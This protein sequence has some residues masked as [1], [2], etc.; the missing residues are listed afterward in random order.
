[1]LQIKSEDSPGPDRAALAR[2]WIE[3]NGRGGYASSTVLN[4]HTRKYHGLLVANLDS[5]PGRHVLFSQFEDSLL[6]PDREYFLSCHQYPG[7]FFPGNDWILKEYRIDPFPSFL[8]RTEGLCL[9]KTILLLPA[10]DCLLV[11]YDIEDCPAK[12]TLRLKPFIAFRGYHD[13]SRRNPWLNDRITSVN[14]GFFLEPYA[15]MPSLFIQTNVKSKFLAAPLW[16]DAFEYSLEGERGYDRHEDL[17]LPGTIEVPVRKGA[18]VVVTAATKPQGKQPKRLWTEEV[19]RRDLQAEERN[20]FASKFDAQDR[21]YIK[22]LIRAGRQFLIRTPAG[23]PAVIAGYHWFG[24]WG[25]DTLISLPGLTFC[26]NRLQEGI[27]ILLEISEHEWEGLLPNCFFAEGKEPSYNS[28]DASLW[29]FWTVQQMLR[30]NGAIA[31][32]KDRFWP[33]MK[34]ILRKFMDGTVHDIRVG[35]NGLLHAG[36]TGSNLTW[37]DASVD[38]TPV[39]PRWGC[40]VE[41]NALWYNAVCFADKLSRDFG[42]EEFSFTGLIPMIRHSF[43]KTFWSERDGHL[44]DVFCNGL[45]D[46][47]IRPNQIFAISLPYPEAE[48][49]MTPEQQASVVQVVQEHLLTPCGLRTLSP[50]H[51]DYQGRYGGNTASRDRAYHQGTVWPWLLGH[52]GEAY[53]GV[54]QE[55]AAAKAFLLRHLRS[56]LGGHLPEAGLGSVSEVFDGDPPHRPGGCISQAWSVAELIRLYVLLQEEGTILG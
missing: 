7:C 3:T 17:F 37:M 40:P 4:C 55:K 33:V 43:Q 2:E 21:E 39:T 29:F 22:A 34:R 46:R 53:L 8:Y 10:E 24:D 20:A 36:H 56:F 18:S 27:D 23:R 41:I 30:Y 6:L 49:L 9:Q 12:A 28:I 38:G 44:G 42:D 35:D 51:R 32:V 1:M 52:F 45:L 13:L 47:A 5:P 31:I 16:Y 48:A 19:S 25:R 26:Q 15:G 14:N 54:R 11:R 50:D